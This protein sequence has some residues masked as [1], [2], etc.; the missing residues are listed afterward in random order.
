MIVSG[1]ALGSVFLAFSKDRGSLHQ[2]LK[3]GVYFYNLHI[4]E[5][6][7]FSDTKKDDTCPGAGSPG[8]VP[9]GYSSLWLIES[10]S[11]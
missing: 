10:K 2:K 3:S 8:Y 6:T 11:Q 4:Q 7:P 1:E 9:D 5:L